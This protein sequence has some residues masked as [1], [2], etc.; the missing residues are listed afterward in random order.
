M[1]I[2]LIFFNFR[3]IANFFSFAGKIKAWEENM[4]VTSAIGTQPEKKKF[5]TSTK[6]NTNDDNLKKNVSKTIIYIYIYIHVYILITE[7]NRGQQFFIIIPH[8]EGRIR[9][10]ICRS[11]FAIKSLLPIRVNSAFFSHI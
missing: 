5:T 8:I 10:Q 7:Y 4:G 9:S 3:L 1:K 6:I 2:Y 11:K